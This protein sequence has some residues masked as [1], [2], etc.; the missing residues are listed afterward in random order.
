MDKLGTIEKKIE[1]IE[2]AMKE[3]TAEINHIIQ[4]QKFTELSQKLET[5]GDLWGDYVKQSFSLG[6][7]AKLKYR[8]K[9]VDD[10]FNEL[11]THIGKY[12]NSVQETQHGS[13]VKLSKL[14]YAIILI[15]EIRKNVSI[16]PGICFFDIY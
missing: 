8:Y 12:F 13:C 15:T 11:E 14:R 16:A 6:V 9:T 4:D 2:F 7:G 5:V 3:Q 1:N 10:T